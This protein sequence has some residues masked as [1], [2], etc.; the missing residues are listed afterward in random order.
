MAEKIHWSCSVQVAGG[1]LV[2]AS[3]AK[4]VEAYDKLQ[5]TIDAS[6][7]EVVKFAPPGVTTELVIV[8]PVTRGANLECELDGGAKVSLDGDGA[9]VLVGGGAA[10]LLKIPDAGLKVTNKTAAPATI[11]ILVGRNPK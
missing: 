3:G 9:V 1:P 2:A 8:N 11:E 10:G 6:G 7:M 5:V 4:D